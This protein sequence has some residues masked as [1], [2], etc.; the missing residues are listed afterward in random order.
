[1]IKSLLL[2]S[3]GLAAA[4]KSDPIGSVTA[5]VG[6][7]LGPAYTNAF[8]FEVISADNATHHDVFELGKKRNERAPT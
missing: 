3:L 6:R 1:M 4:R 2:V 8:T 5:L 7:V